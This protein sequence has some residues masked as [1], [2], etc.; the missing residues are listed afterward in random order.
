M[1]FSIIVAAYNAEKYIDECIS[2]LLLQDFKDYE[3][4]LVDDGS[5]DRTLELVQKYF[6]A[7]NL[8][9]YSQKN[10]GV[11]SARMVGMLR[12]VGE[13][14]LFFDADDVLEDRLFLKRCENYLSI[15]PDIVIF[16]AYNFRDQSPSLKKKLT[17][18][19]NLIKNGVYSGEQLSS[20]LFQ[21][22]YG[23]AW[24]KVFKRDFLLRNR[25][26]FPSLHHSEDLVFVFSSLI[27]NPLIVV[28]KTIEIAHRLKYEGSVS[29][30]Y[31]E[32]SPFDHFSAVEM[33]RKRMREVK[34]AQI[35]QKSFN[36]WVITFL[37]WHCYSMRDF[38]IQKLLIK[39]TKNYLLEELQTDIVVSD[40]KFFPRVK[41]WLLNSPGIMNLLCL[42]NTRLK[43]TIG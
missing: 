33:L 26:T 34:G 36:N 18:L 42:I 25:I 32:Q 2:S 15:S 43:N 27:L 20:F 13:Y 35:Y 17:N 21:F 1:K 24:D 41:F 28:D 23:W 31:R 11:G 37:F 8:K 19:D 14:L 29:G 38:N 4:I 40:L 6:W 7:T 9:V 3:V 5:D 10:Q 39:T 12:S 16:G 30:K 22:C